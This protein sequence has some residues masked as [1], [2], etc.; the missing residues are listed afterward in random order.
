VDGK[1]ASRPPLGGIDLGIGAFSKHGDLA[2]E[3]ARCLA[4][5][6][7]QTEYMADSKNPA[8]RAAAYDD[9]QVRKIFPMADQIRDSINDAEPRPQTPYYNDVS[10]AVV[11]A[12]HPE[13]AVQPELTPARAAKLIADVLHDRVLL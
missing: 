5:T 10:S 4:S 3:A 13:I 11:R 9:A 2:V 12:F 6:E 8:A 7:S 1:A